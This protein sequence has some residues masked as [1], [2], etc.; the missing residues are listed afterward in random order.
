MSAYLEG[1]PRVVAS[2]DLG[3]ARTFF[4]VPMLKEGASRSDQHL[5]SGSP[6]VHRQKDR[7][8][9]ELRHPCR[10]ASVSPVPAGLGPL[11]GLDRCDA[12]GDPRTAQRRTVREHQR[13]ALPLQRFW[14]AG[15][16]AQ[17]VR[18]GQ[19]IAEPEAGSRRYVVYFIDRSAASAFGQCG[20]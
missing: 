10:R 3:G 20:H 5:P 15:Q 18:E 6:T 19:R 17:Y 12:D 7:P 13:L 4:V 8:S 1:D 2:V 11:G 9:R 14:R 16:S